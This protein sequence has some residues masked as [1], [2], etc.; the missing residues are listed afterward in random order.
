MYPQDVTCY[1]VCLKEMYHIKKN[2]FKNQFDEDAQ[3][4]SYKTVNENKFQ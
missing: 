2:S 1:K 3:V 4:W